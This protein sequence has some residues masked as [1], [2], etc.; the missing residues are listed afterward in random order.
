MPRSRCFRPRAWPSRKKAYWL[1]NDLKIVLPILTLVL[2][3][4]GVA[5]ARGHRRALTRGVRWCIPSPTRPP[6]AARVDRPAGKV[7][8]RYG[9]GLDASRSATSDAAPGRWAGGELVAGGAGDRGRRGSAC[10][11]AR[12]VPG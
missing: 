8:M 2:P 12:E 1:I 6:V 5:A 10:G 3:G 4:A 9:I 11:A 7:T